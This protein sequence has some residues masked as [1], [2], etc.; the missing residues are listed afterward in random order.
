MS[1]QSLFSA[2]GYAANVLFLLAGLYVYVSLIRQVKVRRF[3]SPAESSKTFGFPEAILA[4]LLMSLLLLNVA[5]AASAPTAELSTRDLAANLVITAVIVLILIGF[6]MLRGFDLD[7]LAGFSRLG[8]VR[9]ATTGAVLLLAA[10]PLIVVADAITRRFLEDGSARQNIVELFNGSRTMEQ[11][12]III[13]LAVAVA[14]VA[15]ELVFR[16]FLYGVLRRYFGRLLGLV[17]NSLLFAAVHEHLPS[18]GPLF[19][20]GSCFTLAYEWSGS[21]LVP[22][23]MH[24][25]FNSLSLVFLAFPE[26]SQR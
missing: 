22:M 10:Y 23:T 18:F 2:F 21:L 15:E 13:V 25:L 9:A 26:I 7:A 19:V 3:S 12:V 20:L 14:P 17:V 8:I 11:R 1:A 4:A 6:L 16:F 24:S 5:V